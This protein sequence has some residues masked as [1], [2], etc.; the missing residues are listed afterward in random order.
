MIKYTEKSVEKDDNKETGHVSCVVMKLVEGLV[1][2]RVNIYKDHFIA[3]H[4]LQ[5]FFAKEKQD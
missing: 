3:A 4:S 2:F 1:R 5:N